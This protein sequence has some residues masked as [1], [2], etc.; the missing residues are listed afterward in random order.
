M[1]FI[2]H[3]DEPNKVHLADNADGT[4]TANV[5]LTAGAGRDADIITVA[6]LPE[7]YDYTQVVSRQGLLDSVTVATAAMPLCTGEYDTGKKNAFVMYASATVALHKEKEAEA[8]FA[9]E[10]LV[11]RIDITNKAYGTGNN[12]FKLTKARILQAKPA[13]YI[14]PHDLYA[15]PD[16]LTMSD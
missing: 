13:S 16:V 1:A 6:N 3:S 12:A 5:D 2:Y 11:A 4:Y 8:T 10:R 15:S 7:D 14:T 9:M